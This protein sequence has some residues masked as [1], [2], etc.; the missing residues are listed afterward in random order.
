MGSKNFFT[1]LNGSESINYLTCAVLRFPRPPKIICMYI[2][3]Y[4]FFL[5]LYSSFLFYAFYFSHSNTIYHHYNTIISHRCVYYIIES[6]TSYCSRGYF[7]DKG[8]WGVSQLYY[9][10]F[11][12]CKWIVYKE[13]LEKKFFFSFQ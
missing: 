11:L 13:E 7:R 8:V 9:F 1:A 2:Y 12:I 3:I 6:R 5:L 4:T 10:F